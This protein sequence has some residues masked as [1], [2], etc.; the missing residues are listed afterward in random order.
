ML[1]DFPNSIHEPEVLYFLALLDGKPEN[2]YQR[3]LI[4]RYPQSV[5]AKQMATGAIEVT[6]DLEARAAETYQSLL[7]LYEKMNYTQGAIKAE[8][9]YYQ[10]IGT[11]WQDKIAYIRIL[12]LSKGNQIEPY[13]MALQEFVAN[14]Q[15]S[16]FLKDV[17]ERQKVLKP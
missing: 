12:F 6:A 4:D 10:F 17:Q 15:S 3:L 11:K 13:Q 1:E 9:A 8:Q 14:H 16:G 5:F 2:P 7:D